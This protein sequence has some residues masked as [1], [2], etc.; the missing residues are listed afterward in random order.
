LNDAP[1][2]LEL[3]DHF[4]PSLRSEDGTF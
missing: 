3:R 4:L 2:L 1:V